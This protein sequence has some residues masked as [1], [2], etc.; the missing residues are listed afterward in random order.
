[1]SGSLRCTRGV[2]LV[3]LMV[4]LAIGSILITG[5]LWVYVE[6]RKNYS[7]NEAIAQLQNN[8]RFALE[9]LEPDLR[10]AGNYGLTNQSN[11]IAGRADQNDP[12]PPALAVQN[13]CG[14]NWA[15]DLDR[16][17]TASNNAY[18]LACG[19]YNGTARPGTDLLVVRHASVSTAAP[20]S[21]R[22]QIQ[23]SPLQGRLF[24]DGVATATLGAT[25]QV[26]DLVVNGYYVAE[27]ST[28]IGGLPSLRRKTLIGGGV[29]GQIRDEEVVPGVEDFQVQ[30]GIDTTGDDAVNQYVNPGGLPAGARIM[31]VRLWLLVRAERP[32]IGF[33]DDRSYIYADRNLGPFNDNFRRLLISRTIQLRNM[34]QIT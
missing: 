19:P 4:A 11:F 31:A 25:S 28:G 1:M 3:E 23:S 8:A 10:L 22:V 16:P 33:V 18:P 30:L 21:G 26:N 2:T 34:R 27:D 32:E 29:S 24:A 9:M 5:A 7:V 6:S 12:I 20:Q 13:D 14:V 15:I 17:V